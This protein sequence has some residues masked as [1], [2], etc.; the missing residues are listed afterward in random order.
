MKKTFAIACLGAFC[1]FGALSVSA[2]EGVVSA[3][4]LNVRIR[5]DLKSA[6]AVKLDRGTKVDVTGESGE[7]VEIAVPA[8]TPVY[9]S[10]VYVEGSATSAPLKMYV[11][12]NSAAPGYGVLP[13]G[14]KVKVLGID[15]Y[16]WAKIEPPAMIKLYAAKRFVK[17]EATQAETVKKAPAAEK[18]EVKPAEK[19]ETPK[20]T[21]TAEK[22]EP[23]TPAMEK[24]LRELGIDLSKGARVDETGT[25]LKLETTTVPVLRYVLMHN[26]THDYYLCS[27]RVDFGKFGNVPVR[28]AGRSFQ[29]P[30]WKVPVFYV[31]AAAAP[32]K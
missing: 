26:G 27:D 4:L 29:V 6:V 25:L 23:M 32:G 24:T 2:A 9:V 31:E 8:T 10:A 1:T 30:G 16:G 12:G 3:D 15:R 13:R 14:T 17:V 11:A 7:F 22:V 19:T 21:K 5:P 18:T 20:E 28:L